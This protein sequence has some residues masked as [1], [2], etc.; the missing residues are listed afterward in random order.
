MRRYYEANYR[1]DNATLVVVGNIDPAKVEA[2]IKARFADWKP[3][4]KPDDVALGTPVPAAPAGEFVASG[5]QDALSLSWVR[6]ADLRAET[7]AVDREW[8]LRSLGLT[9]LNNRLADRA[10]KPGSPYI[11]G[12]AGSARQVFG[13]AGLTRVGITAAPGAW[14][15]ALAA[16]TQ[17]QRQLLQGGVDA[18]ELKRA[19]TQLLTNYQTAAAQAS[20]RKSGDIADELVQAVNNDEISTSPAQD[21]AFA[22]P[23][24]AAATPG[25]Q[26]R[27]ASGLCGKD[28]CCS[29]RPRAGR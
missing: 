8:V 10:A 15:E 16:V 7:E 23:I 27:P 1:P 28:R 26:C 22:Q 19:V 17:E 14:R 25:G 21:L 20:T 6:P 29:A 13:S 4:G 2:E 11:A 24:L 3:R 5:A 18:Q 9:V 12:Q